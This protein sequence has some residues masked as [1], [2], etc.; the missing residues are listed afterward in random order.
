MPGKTPDRVQFYVRLVQPNTRKID[1]LL[2]ENAVVKRDVEV[3]DSPT[4]AYNQMGR[5]GRHLRFN[6]GR[7]AAGRS[8]F[9]SAASERDQVAG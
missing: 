1:S 9:P 8:G 4:T 6:K 5:T 7:F 2:T 3:P